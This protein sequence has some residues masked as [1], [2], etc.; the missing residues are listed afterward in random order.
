MTPNNHS[1][2]VTSYF[3][4]GWSGKGSLGEVALSRSERQVGNK[5][6]KKEVIMRKLLGGYE[7]WRNSGKRK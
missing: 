5:N 7:E 6:V 2:I 1:V 4:K 3:R